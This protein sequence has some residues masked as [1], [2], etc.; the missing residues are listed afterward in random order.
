MDGISS[1]V[2]D[3][4]EFLCPFHHMRIQWKAQNVDQE[5]AKPGESTPLAP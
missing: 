2:R 4:R 1:L 3:S 5:V